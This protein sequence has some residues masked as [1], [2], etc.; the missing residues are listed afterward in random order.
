M[1][2][3]NAIERLLTFVQ[4]EP[5]LYEGG[6]APFWDDDHIS[7]SMLAAHLDPN[8]DAASRNAAFVQAS[9]EWIA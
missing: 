1:R 4:T 6:T 8:L 5:A 3:D 7:Q 9:A 2:K